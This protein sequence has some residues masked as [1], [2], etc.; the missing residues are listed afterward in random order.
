MEWGGC[1]A[2]LSLGHFAHFHG[3]A[4]GVPLGDLQTSRQSVAADPQGQG[5]SGQGEDEAGHGLSRLVDVFSIEAGRGWGHPL[6]TVQRSTI[7]EFIS[8]SQILESSHATPSG[9][10]PMWRPMCPCIMQRWNFCQG[11]SS[12]PQKFTH[13]LAVL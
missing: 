4:V 11:V 12:A 10:C 6:W 9:V 1:S 7:R 2:A 8:T 5:E 3:E 13:A